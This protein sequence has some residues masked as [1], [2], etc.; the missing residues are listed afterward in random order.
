MT[1]RTPRR[2]HAALLLRVEQFL[3]SRTSLR[4]RATQRPAQ[5]KAGAKILL[6][7]ATKETKDQRTTLAA[8]V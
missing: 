5:I 3:S 1:R 2:Q 7:R 6:A 4:Y 8:D